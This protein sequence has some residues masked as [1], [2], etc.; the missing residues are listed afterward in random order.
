MVGVHKRNRSTR[1]RTATCASRPIRKAGEAAIFFSS[2]IR[3]TRFSRD[4]SSDVCSSD[5]LSYDVFDFGKR[6]A[7]VRERE[8]KLAQAQENLARLKEA[9]S[10]QIERSYNKVERT[11]H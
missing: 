7:V 9:V 8:A 5:L 4:W 6:R 1:G 11:K 10:V 2:I 3:H